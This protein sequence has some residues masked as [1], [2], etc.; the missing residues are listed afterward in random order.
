MYVSIF[1]FKAY[2]FFS[3]LKHAL[4]KKI[5]LSNNITKNHWLKPFV[6]APTTRTS[7]G[8]EIS[9][10]VIQKYRTG[11]G[12]GL[13]TSPIVIKHLNLKQQYKLEIVTIS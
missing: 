9:P 4:L 11:G 8:L 6:M 13:E 2:V 7:P 10:V 1:V 3:K 12:R 5:L